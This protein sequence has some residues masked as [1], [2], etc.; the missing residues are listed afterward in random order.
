M[1]MMNLLFKS[2]AMWICGIIDVELENL[3]SPV[4]ELK[5]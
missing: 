4:R 1:K 5:G 2:E 3:F